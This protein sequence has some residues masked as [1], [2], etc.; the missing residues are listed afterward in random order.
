MAPEHEPDPS[1][2]DPEGVVQA[3][4]TP[5]EVDPMEA[6]AFLVELGI[7]DSV[8]DATPPETREIMLRLANER[9]E[10]DDARMRALADFRNFQR[11]SL[12]NESRARREG[13]AELV[14]CLL[15]AIDHFDLA[16]QSAAT[17]TSV[18]QVVTGVRM[19]REEIVRALG[20][21]GVTEITAPSGDEFEPG[22]HEAIGTLPSEQVEGDAAAGTIAI[23]VAPGFAIGDYVLRPAKVMLVAEGGS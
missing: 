15:P 6:E 12:E 11:R 21:R 22:R 9:R 4:S 14:R 1:P 2:K 8:I 20:A 19:V 5:T 17:A 7:D 3:D 13:S 23:T 16:L 18:D 10:A